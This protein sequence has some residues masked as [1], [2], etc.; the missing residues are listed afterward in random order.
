[1]SANG[2]DAAGYPIIGYE[3]KKKEQNE[4]GRNFAK[5]AAEAVQ[6]SGQVKG[7]MEWKKFLGFLDK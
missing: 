4:V 7:Y 3:A 1:M 2:V 5:Q 6:A